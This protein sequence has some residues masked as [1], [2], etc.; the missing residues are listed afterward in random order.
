MTASQQPPPGIGSGPVLRQRAL[1]TSILSESDNDSPAEG[2][3]LSVVLVSGPKDHGP[4]EH[5]YPLWQSVWSQ[6]LGQLPGVS[7]AGAFEWPS[8]E[9]WKSA[10]LI[11]CYFW[12]H[13]WSDQRYADL[14]QFLGRG[15]GL[16]MFHS[17]LVEDQSPERLARRIGLS[18][19]RPQ[20]QFRHG[21]LLLEFPA[22]DHSGITRG[23]DSTWFVDEVYWE[24]VG[25]RSRVQILAQT[26]EDDLVCPMAWTHHPT[27]G[28]RVF[29]TA[30]GHYTWTFNDPIFRLLALRGMA[31]AA[32]APVARLVAAATDGIEWAP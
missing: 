31:W 16:A 5:D 2:R 21:P 23:I 1:V 25:D 28:G 12:N 8:P 13:R 11:A 14:D 32:G 9:Q 17:A 19:K 4:G 7:V 29:V 26:I 10:D 27:G 30:S 18:G 24:L 20:L 3:P 6:L 15:G 22:T